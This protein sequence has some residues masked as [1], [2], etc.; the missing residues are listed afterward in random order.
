[1][2]KG[3]NDCGEKI[4]NQVSKNTEK[5]GGGERPNQKSKK[6]INYPG[7]EGTGSLREKASLRKMT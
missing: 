2:K 6:G 4:I 7:I 3:G 5:N 1:M